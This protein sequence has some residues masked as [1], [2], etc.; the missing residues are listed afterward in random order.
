MGNCLWGKCGAA[1]QTP[2]IDHLLSRVPL[3]L[4]HNLCASSHEHPQSPTVGSL[5]S[6]HDCMAAFS[7]AFFF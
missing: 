3:V 4:Q 2:D 7:S 1:N 5:F 6:L